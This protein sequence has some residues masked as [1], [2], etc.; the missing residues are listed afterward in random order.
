MALVSYSTD[1][2]PRVFERNHRSV[3][4]AKDEV[5][6]RS[7]LSQRLKFSAHVCVCV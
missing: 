2:Q 5:I 7:R 1:D 3:K 4:D 6:V